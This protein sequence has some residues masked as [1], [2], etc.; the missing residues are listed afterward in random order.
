[1]VSHR[2]TVLLG[3]AVCMALL[4]AA[5]RSS[6]LFLDVIIRSI[7]WLARAPMILTLVVALLVLTAAA[8]AWAMVVGIKEGKR[9]RISRRRKSRA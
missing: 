7:E 4:M 3:V 1:M 9:T 8:G 2:L 5:Q 6:P